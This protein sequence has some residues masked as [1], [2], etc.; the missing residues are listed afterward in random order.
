M[1]R[2]KLFTTINI[3]GLSVSIACCLL[4]FVYV[5]NQLGYDKQ[6]GEHI[7]RLTSLLNQKNGGELNTA[8]SSPP[9]AH[10]IEID[11]PEIEI[12]SRITFTGILGGKD[13]ISH[14]DDSFYIEGGA[15]T[16]STIF[17]VLNFDFAF[18]NSQNP[19]A[20]GNSII[21]NTEWSNK[22][23]GEEDPI[24]QLVKVS[25]MVGSSEF[26]VT[27]IYDEKTYS[28]HLLPSF[29]VPIHNT[30][31]NNFFRNI[32]TQWVGNNLV[33]TYLRLTSSSNPKD[34]EIKIDKI[35]QKKGAEQMEATGLSKVMSLQPIGSI[36]TTPGYMGEASDIVSVTFI[37]V[38]AG[39]GL[40]I[41]ILACVNYINLSTAQ[42]GNRALE[43]GV[44]KVMGISAKGL[45]IQFLGESFIIILI[46]LI[47]SILIAELALPIFNQLIDHP[48]SFTLTNI[49]LIARYM[50]LFLIGITLLAGIYPAIYLSSFKPSTVLKG[51]NKDKGS[52]SLLRK[53]LVTFQFVISIVLISAILIISDQVSFIKN[54]DL[55]FES[56]SRIVV[57]L[58]TNELQGKF[59]LIK[60]QF[61]TL[62]QVKQ[63]AGT[64]V[65]PGEMMTNDLLIY[66]S[67][68]TMDDAIHI[69]NN[70]V[71]ND[72]INTLEIDLLS[73][74]Q[75]GEFNRQDSITKILINREA[76]SQL[77]YSVEEAV[78]ELLFFD[79]MGKSY[80]FKIKGV[81][82]N[83]N[84]FSLHSKIEP[85]MLTLRG[86]K[87][88]NMIIETDIRDYTAT[89]IALSSIWKEVVPESPFESFV[90]NDHLI[91]QYQSDFKTFN[92]IKYFAFISVFISA[93][94]LYALSMFIAERRFKEI[95]VRKAL[96]AGIKDIIVLVSKDL[97][98]L[99]L[100]AF[101]LSIPIS[102]YGMN[103]WLDTFAY[104][105]TPGVITY[106]IAGISS[107]LIAWLT[108]SY[109]S[110]KAART[111][112]VDVLKD[113]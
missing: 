37:N 105:I 93:M 13:M 20:H 40:L 65:N 64:T 47:T 52:V 61:S 3:L 98:L 60:Q 77:G 7:Y 80:N 88:A 38:L 34:V 72:Y 45:I 92:L 78:G 76:A 74:K 44:R 10:A 29:I 94:G 102:I 69:F 75:L 108:I 26:E 43:V 54:K 27:A 8:S 31:W 46:S 84:Q 106:L 22:L 67:G 89:V 16:D 19:L 90:L 73:G 87:F 59:K 109:Q 49:G 113:E 70:D 39:I 104:R 33:Y 100:I 81:V 18:G 1:L 107:V 57:P 35:F 68:Q 62:S 110:I 56:K 6:H 53:F 95:G 48:I 41:L 63:I 101:I 21:L 15:V 28:S 4:L 36:H 11:I 42:A 12:A 51:R 83:V 97:S 103:I 66:R 50:G 32:S 99:V 79:W 58:S 17:D 85:L 5:S 9:T 86:G 82:E 30:D 23:F 91:N 14:G 112:P 71:D 25:T 24:G 96:G 111:N 55:G 2:N